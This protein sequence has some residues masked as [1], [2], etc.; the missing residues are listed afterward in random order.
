MPSTTTIRTDRPL[1][2]IWIALA[3]VMAVTEPPSARAAAPPRLDPV[4]VSATRLETPRHNTAANV[5]VVSREQLDN[6]PATSV[7]EALQYVPGVYVEFNGGPGSFAQIRIQGSEIRHVTVLRDGVPLNQLANPV[8]DL[9]SLSLVA[10][11]RIEI[12]KGAASSAWGSALGGVVNIVTRDPAGQRPV[13]GEAQASYGEFDTVKSRAVVG[14]GRGAF[15]FRLSAARDE[16]DGII[17]HSEFERDALHAA[18]GLAAGTRARF[19]LAVSWDRGDTA[20]PA[21]DFPGFWDDI[22]QERD[23][24]RLLLELDL[25]E[26][27]YLE[28]EGRHHRYDLLIEDVFPARRVVFNDYADETWGGGAR[29]TWRA[30]GNTLLAGFDGDWGSYDWINYSD[31]YDTGNWAVYLQ[32]AF[33]HG[34]WSL[35]AG[36]RHD[37]NDDFGDRVSPSAGVVYRL[38]V[39]GALIR[40][41]VAGGFSAP[42]AAWVHDPQWGEPDLKPETALNLQAGGEI[43]PLPWLHA[44]VNVF[45]AEVE[46]LIRFDLNTLRFANIDAVTRQGVEGGVRVSLPGGL[47]F[48]AGGSYT[49]VRD[50]VTD[51]VV[52]DIPRSQL[53][54][55]AGYT[56]PLTAHTLTGRWVDHNS[57][58][59]ETNDQ[60]FVFDYAFRATLPWPSRDV[61]LTV[62]GS[63]Y[64]IF[65]TGY[66]YR[67]I[68]PQPGRWMEAGLRLVF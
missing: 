42:P 52:A 15:D 23:Y 41:Q 26:S 5:T 4:V 62:F 27:L 7:A 22:Q 65:D 13:S 32:D 46:D 12:V 47:S 31:T 55:S 59:P 56:H 63:V 25:S 50:D 1:R 66:L 48:G 49:D 6:L 3:A 33:V 38:P 28:V 2:V 60:V 51:E 43:Q 57:D 64:N 9:S 39:A 58:Y 17:P 35:N 68:W 16:S 10:V 8:T 53:H 61:P 37:H 21:L 24:Q 20:D 54:L 36:L 11:E 45:R 30:G 14:G 29:L 44:E 19:T 18:L 34:P 40:G 67:D